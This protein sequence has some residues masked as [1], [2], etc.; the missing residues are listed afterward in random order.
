MV[1]KLKMCT[2]GKMFGKIYLKIITE[3]FCLIC[4]LRSRE[5]REDT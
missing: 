2:V 5:E 3:A 1:L 4:R